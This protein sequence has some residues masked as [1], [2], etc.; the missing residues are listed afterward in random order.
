M[1]IYFV[2]HGETALNQKGA[3]YGALDVP[4]T[5]RGYSQAEKIAHG[6]RFVA[7]DK[8]YI[9]DKRR[10]RETAMHMIETMHMIKGMQKNMQ[11]DRGWDP[12]GERRPKLCTVPEL[13]ELHFGCF[14]GLTN[15]Q[16]IE[17]FPEIYRK[18]CEDWQ[19]FVLPG[20]ESFL[21]FFERV[22]A[23]FLHILEEAAREDL[24]N[25]LICVHNGTLRV[26]FAVM[27]GLLPEGT[28]HFNFEQDAYSKV[29]YEWE[30]FTIRSMNVKGEET[31][32]G[33]AIKSNDRVDSSD[34]CTDSK[35]HP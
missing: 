26:I 16:V 17:K 21:M 8:V 29:D 22:K 33:T 34:R 5:A 7:F 4:L 9:S 12:K 11:K 1:H 24:K 2:R 27:C 30:N 10:S 15:E 6:L 19:G 14:E 28:W 3:Y 20:G 35:N 13:C 31:Y 18:W 23:A 32:N 25:I